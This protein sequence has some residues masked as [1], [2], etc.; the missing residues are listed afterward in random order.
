MIDLTAKGKDGETV[1]R[2][3]ELFHYPSDNREPDLPR[4]YTYDKNLRR[5]G[6]GTVGAPALA[7]EKAQPGG[8]RMGVVRVGTDSAQKT[9]G[10][11]L[12]DDIPL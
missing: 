7:L 9:G 10:H 8:P 11:R 3:P 2:R 5:S 12:P 1:W 4:P 6:Y